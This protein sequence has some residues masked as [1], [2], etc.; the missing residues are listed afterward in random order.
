MCGVFGKEKTKSQKQS[1]L[2]FNSLN[3]ILTNKILDKLQYL[4]CMFIQ[5]PFEN[6]LASTHNQID[7][8][9]Q[10]TFKKSSIRDE[11]IV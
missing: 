2:V 4:V 6:V 7:P 5:T 10:Y 3:I 9:P 11:F 1:G 8:D